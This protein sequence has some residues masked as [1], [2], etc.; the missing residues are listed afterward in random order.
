[1]AKMRGW[2]CTGVAGFKA[3]TRAAEVPRVTQV[4]L[5]VMLPDLALCSEGLSDADPV[6][7]H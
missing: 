4:I 5:N 7:Q 3:Q 1:M 6:I 2:P